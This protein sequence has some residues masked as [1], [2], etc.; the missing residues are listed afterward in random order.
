M[1]LL[2]IAVFYDYFDGKGG[3]ERQ[4]LN[5]AKGLRADIYTCFVNWENVDAE[6][7]HFNIHEI[8]LIFKES[9]VLKRPE[10]FS[11]YSTLSVEGYDVYLFC[12][13]H[14]LSATR[15]K[16][17]MWIAPGIIQYIY[18]KS[19]HTFVSSSYL[20]KWQM[21]FFDIWCS[22][23]KRLDQA[24][25]K[26]ID[27]IISNSIQTQTDIIKYY[28]RDSK[29]VYPGIDTSKFKCKSYENFILLPSR[30]VKEK[31]IDLIINAFKEM[32]NRFLLIAGD[33]SEKKNLENLAYGARNIHFLGSL[34]YED[35][36]DLYSRCTATIGM[37]ISESF[38]LVPV[39]SMASG[40]PAVGVNSTGYKETIL[41]GRTGF[42]IEPTKEEIKRAVKLLTPEFAATMKTSCIKQAKRFDVSVFIEKVREN[43][44][45][46]TLAN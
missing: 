22:M 6:M 46:L 21:P 7:R 45:D 13:L 32:P 36:I 2:K 4:V 25:V 33:G 34:N 10:I 5:L 18:D 39:E 29:I 43:I 37:S 28:G 41:S 12:G 16:P 23:Y 26:K 19:E 14:C 3:A 8:G 44:V 17:N 1:T 31:R 42:L 24:W 30:L 9:K 11:R 15:N 20:H 35:L 27:K 38:G 40:K